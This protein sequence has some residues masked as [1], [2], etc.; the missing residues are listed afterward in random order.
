MF[1]MLKGFIS[2]RLGVTLDEIRKLS[3]KLP[4]K[5]TAASA[6]TGIDCL[7]K[8]AFD[9]RTKPVQ[10]TLIKVKKA[11]VTTVDSN[12]GDVHTIAGSNIKPCVV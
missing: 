2:V 8:R 9:I 1:D 6:L 12:F 5:G 11:D 3:G 7:V 10:L 4:N